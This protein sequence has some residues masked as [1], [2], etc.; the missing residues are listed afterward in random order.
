MN[1]PA[2]CCCSL[3]V[4]ATA[5]APS[6]PAQSMPSSEEGARVTN[7]N[8]QLADSISPNLLLRT[9]PVFIEEAL[10]PKCWNVVKHKLRSVLLS[11]GASK[12]ISIRTMP[13]H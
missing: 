11:L 2:S 10:T 8:H 4:L 6:L 9:L 5:T 12:L 1:A 7:Y 13:H 3:R